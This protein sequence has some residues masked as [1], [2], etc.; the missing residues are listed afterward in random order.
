LSKFDDVKIY[1]VSPE[2]I[3]IKEDIKEHLTEKNVWFREEADLNSVLPHIDVAYFTRLQAE[4]FRD[5]E[6]LCQQLKK[7]IPLYS[8]TEKN[9]DLVP[10]QAIV[11]HPLPI[12]DNEIVEEIKTD[13]RIWAFI[14]SDIGVATRMA[15]INRIFKELGKLNMHQNFKELVFSGL[16]WK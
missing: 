4:R 16:G 12:G 8:L 14:Q 3:S 2:E 7:K 5:Q 15:L 6:E 11:T 13:P 9:L 10:Q 1:L